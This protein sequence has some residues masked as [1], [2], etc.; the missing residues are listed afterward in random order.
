LPFASFAFEQF[1]LIMHQISLCPI[2]VFSICII[3]ASENMV[4]TIVS[5]IFP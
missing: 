2:M 4:S 5:P 3:F 1:L